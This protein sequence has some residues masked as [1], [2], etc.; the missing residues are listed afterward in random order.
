[1]LGRVGV[2]DDVRR[3][4]GTAERFAG[5]GE[6]V[7]AVFATEPS[8]GQRTYLV[9]FSANGDDGRTWLAL[10]DTGRPVM[11]RDRVREAVSIAAMCEV[12]EE[13]VAEEPALVSPRLAS[14]AHL[15]ALGTA[16]DAQLAPAIQGA[17]AAVEE[18]AK[19]VEAH[20]KVELT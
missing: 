1:M 11:S 13:A 5:A 4:A 17:L 7:A 12:V 6:Q 9:A 19:D 10:D 3:I 16:S 8:E 18:L 14:P 15:D 2:S 20:Y